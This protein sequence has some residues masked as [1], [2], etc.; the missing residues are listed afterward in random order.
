LRLLSQFVR[1]H[2]LDVTIARQC[3]AAAFAKANVGSGK[4]KPDEIARLYRKGIIV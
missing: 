4:G 2:L 3:V 1:F